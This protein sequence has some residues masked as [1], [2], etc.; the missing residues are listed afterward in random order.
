MMYCI[1]AAFI[2]GSKTLLLVCG[3]RKVL[4]LGWQAHRHSEAHAFLEA[5]VVSR[6]CLD[7]L[8]LQF[9][10]CKKGFVLCLL[11]RQNKASVFLDILHCRVLKL[12]VSYKPG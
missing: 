6:K 7:T 10:D 12:V 9:N 8:G 5:T 11:H 3:Y 1:V 4:Y 2:L